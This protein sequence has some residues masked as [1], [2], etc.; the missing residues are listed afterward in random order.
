VGLGGVI[1]TWNG[2]AWSQATS[3]T[4]LDL[5][6][7][8]ADKT[9]AFA[10]G[11]T[12]TAVMLKGTAWTLMPVLIPPAD[13]SMPPTPVVN[14]LYAVTKVGAT[15]YAFGTLGI[16]ASYNVGNNQFTSATIPNFFKA[17]V[18]AT[19]GP[20]GSFAVGIDGSVFSIGGG[21][22]TAI[23]GFPLTYLRAVTAPGSDVFVAGWDGTVARLRAGKVL[24]YPLNPTIWYRGVWGATTTDIWVVGASSILRGPPMM[25][26]VVDGGADGPVDGGGG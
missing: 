4:T 23:K 15:V 1:L 26:P 9:S 17:L 12:G 14:Q 7:V 10:V 5:Y 11:Q 22:F 8:Y 18:G 20:G 3:P 13:P 21:N 2:T 19:S 16:A 6:A 24:A 25:D